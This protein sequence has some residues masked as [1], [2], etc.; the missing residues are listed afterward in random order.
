LKRFVKVDDE[1]PGCLVNGKVVISKIKEY[2][3]EVGG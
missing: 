2:F 3:E 1:I